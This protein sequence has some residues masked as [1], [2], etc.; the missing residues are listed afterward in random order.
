[1]RY[2]NVNSQNCRKTKSEAWRGSRFLKE[3]LGWHPPPESFEIKILGNTIFAI[4]RQSQ[5][6]LTSGIL[7]MVVTWLLAFKDFKNDRVPLVFLQL[8]DVIS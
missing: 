2:S 4:L 3:E 5:R 8:F 7:N 6:V 1:M